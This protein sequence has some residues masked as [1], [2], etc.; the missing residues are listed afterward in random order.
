[1]NKKNLLL[2]T[3]VMMAAMLSFG[4]V[5]C[6]SDSD[7]GSTFTVKGKTYAAYAYRGGGMFDNDYYDV[8]WVY[9]FTS[10]TQ[11]EKTTRQS[12]ATGGIIGEIETGTYVLNYP[13]ITI[14]AE[15]GLLEGSVIKGTFI[16]NSTFRVGSGSNVMEYKLQ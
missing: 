13:T 12:S 8:Y 7:D 9:K 1:M 4:F 14:S 10:D 11:Y 6:S 5:S 15:A 2:L 3:T 16:D